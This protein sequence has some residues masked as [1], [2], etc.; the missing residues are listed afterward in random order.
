MDLFVTTRMTA[1]GLLL[2]S[3]QMAACG[4]RCTNPS[5]ETLTVHEDAPTL[6]PLDHGPPGNS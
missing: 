5:S 6:N 1:L 2:A 4:L 3:T